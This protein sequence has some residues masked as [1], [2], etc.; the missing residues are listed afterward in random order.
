M[1]LSVDLL[2]S[3]L[4]NCGQY[5]VANTMICASDSDE[6]K[7]PMYDTMTFCQVSKLNKYT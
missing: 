7:N 4:D 6:N 5:Y 3:S 2:P 1:Q